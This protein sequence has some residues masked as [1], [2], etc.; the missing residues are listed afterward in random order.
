[1]V[2]FGEVIAYRGETELQARVAVIPPEGDFSRSGTIRTLTPLVMEAFG[3][4][5]LEARRAAARAVAVDALRVAACH[6]EGRGPGASHSYE[7]LRA[8]VGEEVLDCDEGVQ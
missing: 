4:R 1:V 3:G 7:A 8:A 6:A 5:P 2:V